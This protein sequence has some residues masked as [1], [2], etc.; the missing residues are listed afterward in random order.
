MAQ[1]RPSIERIG[2]PMLGSQRLPFST[3][4]RAGETVYLSG[5]LGITPDPDFAS[6]GFVYVYYTT[7]APSVHNR[8]S[9]FTA[10]VV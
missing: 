6:N 3:A 5:A 7:A 4:V 2:E 10:A 8:V 9:R 1:D